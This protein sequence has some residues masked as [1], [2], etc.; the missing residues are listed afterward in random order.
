MKYLEKKAEKSKESPKG[1]GKRPQDKIYFPGLNGLR[2]F[3]AAA[4][5]VEHLEMYRGSFTT[6]PSLSADI[7][8]LGFWGVGL[9]FTLSGFLITYLLL[10]EQ[11]RTGA[12]QVKEFYMRRILR[13]WPLYYLVGLTTFLVFWR[14]VDYARIGQ[15][16]HDS[17]WMKA[18]LF[19]FFLP[20]FARAFYPTVV[21]FGQAWSVG[22]EEQFYLIWPHVVKRNLNRLV[23][24]LLGMIAAKVIFYEAGMKLMYYVGQ[25]IQSP[26]FIANGDRFFDVVDW[27]QIEMLALGAIGACLVFKRSSLLR[28]IYH[29]AS[30]ALALVL[31]GISLFYTFPSP[32]HGV[33]HGLVF[34]VL[35]LN[36]ACNPKSILKLENAF[37]NYMGKISYGFYLYHTILCYL[38]VRYIKNT[39]GMYAAVFG[40]TALV[41]AL[42]YKYFES[43]YLQLKKKH[44]VV[45]SGA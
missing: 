19:F 29:P 2:F 10:E 25:K 40:G 21:G 35:I 39:A 37:Y 11:A 16:F 12:I 15:N 7:G 27:F 17:F 9:F 23:A 22:V 31:A 8:P 5:I 14:F 20:N 1:A 44:A 4:V 33:F 45:Q 32:F 26:A 36:V 13:I 6:Q 43:F 28:F 18:F 3:A 42:S 30:Q 24:V 34:L 41:S 38:A